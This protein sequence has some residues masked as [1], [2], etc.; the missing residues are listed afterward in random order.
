MGRGGVSE[1]GQSECGW[2]SA[3]ERTPLRL[4]VPVTRLSM[5]GKGRLEPRWAATSWHRHHCMW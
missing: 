5:V 1:C 4:E 3:C 2:V